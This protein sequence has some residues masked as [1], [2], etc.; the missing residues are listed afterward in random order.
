MPKSTIS[1]LN[2]VPGRSRTVDV[3]LR[4]LTLYP[5]EVRGLIHELDKYAENMRD[6]RMNDL[7]L[8]RQLLYPTEV[9]RQIKMIN[10]VYHKITVSSRAI[11]ECS[12]E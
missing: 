7:L 6:L 1:A 3:Q 4:R 2:G 11:R 8:R 10:K 9:Q 5:T 12:T